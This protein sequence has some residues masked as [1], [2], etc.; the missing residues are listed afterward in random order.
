MPSRQDVPGLQAGRTQLAWERTAL[1]LLG[2]GALLSLRGVH[3]T[4]WDIVVPAALA[5]L[6][7]LVVVVLGRQRARQLRDGLGGASAPRAL[8]AVGGAVVVVGV[9]VVVVL[10]YSS[11]N[12]I[13]AT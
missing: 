13:R 12:G 1:A 4:G 10:A 7:A 9:A 8:S 3:G 5:V 6:A 11:T 2:N